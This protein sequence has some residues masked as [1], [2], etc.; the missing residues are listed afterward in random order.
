[1]YYKGHFWSRAKIFPL[2]HLDK[3]TSWK[4]HTRQ[5]LRNIRQCPLPI[6]PGGPTAHQHTLGPKSLPFDMSTMCSKC[7]SYWH[8]SR[9]CPGPNARGAVRKQRLTELR[10]VRVV[11]AT[12]PLNNERPVHK[13]VKKLVA[14]PPPGRGYTLR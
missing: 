9:N 12:P 5:S 6:G 13:Y 14:P 3:S 7:G 2:L 8:L 11:Q 1:M 4:N 10:K